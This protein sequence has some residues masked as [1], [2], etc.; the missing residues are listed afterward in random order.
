MNSDF[1]VSSGSLQVPVVVGLGFYLPCFNK[2]SLLTGCLHIWE[3][4]GVF[5]Q[6]WG[7]G[8]ACYSKTD[9]E[10]LQKQP[11][12]LPAMPPLPTP[13]VKTLSGLMTLSG[14][15]FMPLSVS[16]KTL[17]GRTL[18]GINIPLSVKVVYNCPHVYLT[19]L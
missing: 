3:F 8:G 18:T 19:K 16:L 14:I 1:K 4:P 7:G 5:H 12:K 2:S 6:R 11:T 17:S 15:D 10:P 13:P 9:A